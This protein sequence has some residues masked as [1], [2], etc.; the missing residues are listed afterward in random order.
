MKDE[1]DER[2]HLQLFDLIARDWVLSSVAE[3]VL[4]NNDATALAFD[5]ADGTVRIAATAD[6]ASPNKRMRRAA[7]SARLTIAPRT[8]PVAALKT[9]DCTKARTSLVVAHGPSHF[10]FG[11]ENGRVNTTTPGGISAYQPFKALGPVSAIT[12]TAQENGPLAYATGCDVILHRQGS[13]DDPEVVTL[14]AKVVSLAFSPDGTVLAIGHRHGTSV[15]TFSAETPGFELDQ[16]STD[17]VW[18]SDGHWLACCLETP[19]FALIDFNKQTA[20]THE[21]FAG[22]V[23]SIAF[24]AKNNTV[25]ASGAFRLAAWD[26]QTPDKSIETGK[27]GLTLIEVIA[28]CPLRNLV[29]VG[30]ANGLVSVAQIGKPGEILLRE[31]TGAAITAMA[32]SGDGNF[33]GIAGADG[34]AALAEFPDDMFKP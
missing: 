30:Y 33:L 21:N 10:A 17:L 18:S 1:R 34:T 7:D 26:L 6:K 20:V 22:P 16:K 19:G 27:T 13:E 12:A 23:K 11:T 24:D 3:R 15:W 9:A 28:S 2:E 25:I 8:D 5:C 4:F 29:A 31:N 14:P 32:W